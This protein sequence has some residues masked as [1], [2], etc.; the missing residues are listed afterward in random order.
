MISIRDTGVRKEMK[1][2]FYHGL[3]LGILS[4]IDD[5]MV[6]SN[7]ESGDGCSDISIEIR[8]REIGIVI[9]L[10][11]AEGGA[12]EGGCLEA[13]KQIRERRYEES[14]LKDGMKT[15]YRYGIACY[16]KRCRVVSE[17]YSG[18]KSD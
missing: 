6:Q 2:N 7:A 14:L 4:H 3:L 15:I 5:W 17:Q 9:E 16:R 1:E 10:K 13:M 18:R 12:F 11:Y 8:N